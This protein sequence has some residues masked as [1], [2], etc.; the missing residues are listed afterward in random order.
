MSRPMKK[1][2][3]KPRKED[4]KKMVYT[5][6]DKNSPVLAW[7]EKMRATH[8]QDMAPVIQLVLEDAHRTGWS[9]AKARQRREAA[10][11]EPTEKP[12][13]ASA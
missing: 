9:Y 8:D 3:K 11:M 10:A 2:K 5:R 12:A 6:F 4:N 13:A 1:K 7:L